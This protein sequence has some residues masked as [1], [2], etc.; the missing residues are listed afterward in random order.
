MELVI[1]KLNNELKEVKKTQFIL[2][3]LEQIGIEGFS[4]SSL[5][6]Y[7]RNPYD[8]YQQRM[9]KVN[10]LEEINNKLSAI[11]KGTLMHEVL[12]ILYQPYI[13]EF[14]TP[15]A[16]DDMLKKLSVTLE[17]SSDTMNRKGLDKTGKNVLLFQVIE[18]V[19]KRFLIAEKRQVL[20]GD[21]IK[22]ISLEREFLKPV[23]IKALNKKIN[24]KGTV[25]RIDI[26]NNTLRFVDYKTGR[27]NETDLVFKSWDE[28]IIDS[29]KNTIFQVMLYVYLLKDEFHD[30][31]IIAGVI[32]L[33][34]FKN[35][36]L[37]VSQKENM[38]NKK[39]L[40]IGKSVLS[41]FEKELLK[42]ICEIFDPSIPFTEKI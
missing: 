14:L 7:I 27:I 21:K 34:T 39:N 4:P 40:K 19:L 37:V 26:Y 6:Q 32:P 29:K 8:F 38:R 36:F 35:N 9:L 20:N 3:H 30:N 23:Y 33:K 12:Q 22:I 11:E 17:K 42:L 31:D 5:S 16:Y 24:F 25:D 13:S 15:I 2:D 18:E 10:S 28:I 1:P 41:Y